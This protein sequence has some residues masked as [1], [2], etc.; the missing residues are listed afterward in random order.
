MI[1][2]QRRQRGAND[3]QG[4]STAPV[5]P[6]TTAETLTPRSYDQNLCAAKKDL[7]SPAVASQDFQQQNYP[8]YYTQSGDYQLD[9]R[10]ETL[11][12]QSSPN[13]GQTPNGGGYLNCSSLAI[14]DVDMTCRDRTSEF[15]RIVEEERLKKQGAGLAQGRPKPMAKRSEFMNIA[16]AI[17]VDIS[18]TFAKLE[19]LTILAKKK[20]LF[21][22]RP[23][24]I[25]DL[26]YIIKQDI[27][28]LNRQIAHL[29]EFSKSRDENSQHA[30]K[31][32]SSVV[33]SLQSKLANMSKSFKQVLEIRTENLK[34]Q[35]ER[36]DQFSSQPPVVSS[37]LPPRNAQGGALMSA[38][39]HSPAPAGAASG[40]TNGSV[41]IDMD[42]DDGGAVAGASG[43]ASGGS[44]ATSQMQQQMQQLAL[45]DET[46][47]Y[48]QER[49]DA[50]QNIESTVV[51]LGQI[52]T[53]LA[54]M[55]KE[56]EEMIQRIDANVTD[57][58]LNV[59]AA[60]GEILKY[61]QSVTSNRWL[62][63]KVFLV[64]IVFFII[65]IVFLA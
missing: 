63:I 27:S 47:S 3:P 55:V 20:S 52:F 15:F 2:R 44:A 33:V 25:Q 10:V 1:A 35:K 9:N 43:G 48:I 57:T 26:T 13:H 60:H 42:G 50:M 8:S 51:E 59:E 18:N 58:E 34:H 5:T 46:D 37:A 19:K 41:M 6:P 39:R 40:A 28:S 11:S 16:K 21:D 24:E 29:Q 7:Y 4:F 54:T 61:F 32:S 23:V 36:R 22:D 65:F 64:L 45:I 49:S 30:K 31:H 62:M 12:F 14:P 38:T 53:Q 17:G 56:Q